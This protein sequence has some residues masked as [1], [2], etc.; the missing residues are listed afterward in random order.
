[1]SGGVVFLGGGLWASICT[2]ANTRPTKDPGSRQII[3]ILPWFIPVVL[4][5]IIPGFYAIAWGVPLLNP[6]T[7]GVLFM[8]E[9]SVGAIS[10]A[11]LTDEPFGM[12]EILGVGLI[13]A[14]GL[15]E[16][17]TVVLSTSFFTRR[18]SRE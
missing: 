15:T 9:I 17:F 16:A 13:T 1:M 4:V 6:G 3:G 5:L 11:L 18:Q 2:I 12:R 14:A 8:T 7:V 10:A